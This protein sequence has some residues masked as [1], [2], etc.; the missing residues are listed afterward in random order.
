MSLH[1]V[2][3]PDQVARIGFLLLRHRANSLGIWVKF[4]IKTDSETGSRK[5]V[6][7]YDNDVIGAGR[8]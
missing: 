1:Y 8:K 4:D 6:L 3:S 7:R 2:L 5:T